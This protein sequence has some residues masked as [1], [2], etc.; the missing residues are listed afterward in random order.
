MASEL[1]DKQT[2]NETECPGG[3]GGG[4]LPR[5]RL[6]GM[7]CWMGVHFHGWIDCNGVAFSLELLE[8][9]HTN[10][11]QYATKNCTKYKIKLN[12]CT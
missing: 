8:W 2:V 5:N 12:S 1:E 9:D 6:M 4:L 11:D 3:G 7:C 10:P